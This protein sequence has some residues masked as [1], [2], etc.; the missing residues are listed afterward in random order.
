MSQGQL[1]PLLRFT[2]FTA[3]KASVTPTNAVQ[4]CQHGTRPKPPTG[5]AVNTTNSRYTPTIT[6]RA[7]SCNTV[8]SH[9]LCR[10][11]KPVS[12]PQIAMKGMSQVDNSQTTVDKNSNTN[13]PAPRLAVVSKMVVKKRGNVISLLDTARVN[14]SL[15]G[16]GV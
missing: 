4:R 3:N 2:Q 13:T 10:H 6:L 7:R 8:S 11:S 16:Q 14:R 12:V 9:Q 1:V 5:Q 15:N